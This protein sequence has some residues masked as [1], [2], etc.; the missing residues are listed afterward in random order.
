MKFL[1]K[2][3]VAAGITAIA[4]FGFAASSFGASTGV[5]NTETVRMRKEPTTESAI[6]TLLSEDFKVDILEQE[7]EWYKVKY[8]EYTGYVSSQYIKTQDSIKD[9]DE[10]EEEVKQISEKDDDNIVKEEQKDDEDTNSIN[11]YKKVED[12]TDVNILPLIN[13]K[14]VGKIENEEVYIIQNINGWS[15][16]STDNIVGWIRTDKLTQKE[17]HKVEKAEE[18]N[19]QSTEED[20]TTKKE[21]TTKKEETAEEI[22]TTSNEEKIAYINNSSVNFREKPSTESEVIYT[23]A[24]N[25]QITILAEENDWYKIKADDKIGYVAKSLISDTKTEEKVSS[26]S[27][28]EKRE[29]VIEAEDDEEVE[30]S[31]GDS[32]LGEEIVEYAKS[33][34]GCKYVYGGTSPAG[35]DCSGF[36]QYVYRHFGYSIS[37]TS[38]TQANDGVK[39]NKAGLEPGD[40]LIF[41]AYND[42]SRIGHVGLYIGNNQFIHASDET[43]GVI[44][45]SL[46]GSNA[47][48]F[49][50][51][52]RII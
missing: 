21:D 38:S 27:Q 3:I 11:V 41:L 17:Q 52:R 13:S 12:S 5:V 4:S 39:V 32:E 2:T 47:S 16:V 26:R 18:K 49:L 51:G 25:K 31:S 15:Y 14:T 33:F 36:V 19:E 1:K 46:T 30:V 42:S 48:R 6:V 7:G 44:I 28:E 37:R 35:F 20:S 23:L 29:E 22:N 50:Y 43:T 45:S 34:L 9:T 40:I 24:L 10:K 8:N